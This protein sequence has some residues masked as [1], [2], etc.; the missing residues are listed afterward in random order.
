MLLE[1]IISLYCIINSFVLTGFTAKI[2]RSQ[3]LR[4]SFLADPMEIL[5]SGIHFI[6]ARKVAK[7]KELE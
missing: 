6:L 3:L 2:F 5:F 1:C 4:K 7:L